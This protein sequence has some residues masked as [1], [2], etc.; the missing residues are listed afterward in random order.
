MSDD[1]KLDQVEQDIETAEEDA[2]RD[3][4][5]GNDEPRFEQTGEASDIEDDAIAPG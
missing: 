4:E 5:P 2:E 3:L 1:P